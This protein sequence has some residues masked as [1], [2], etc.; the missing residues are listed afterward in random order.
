M[1]FRKSLVALLVVALVLGSAVSASAGTAFPDVANTKYSDASAR[2]AGLGVLKGYQDGTFKPD[3]KITRA[4]F[5]AVAVR[6]LGLEA[7]AKL[8]TGATQFPDVPASHWSSGYVNVAVNQGL[9]KGYPDGTFK[10]DANVTNAEALAILVRVIGRDTFVKGVWP[11]N[12]I[13]EA[14]RLGIDAGASLNANDSATR[15]DV[16]LFSSEALTTNVYEQQTTDTGA[17]V[18]RDTGKT[19][20]EKFLGVVSGTR[21]VSDTPMLFSSALK[22]NEVTLY[23]STNISQPWK[24]YTVA[25]GTDVRRM[26]GEIVT[27]YTK[28]DKLIYVEPKYVSKVERVAASEDLNKVNSGKIPLLDGTDLTFTGSSVTYFNNVPYDLSNRD[29][30]GTHLSWNTAR[31]QDVN[32]GHFVRYTL[33]TDG[34]VRSAQFFK[35]A[36]INTTTSGVYVVKEAT[37][38]S[39]KFVAYE[40]KVGATL[41]DPANTTFDLSAARYTVWKG[42]FKNPTAGSLSDVKADTIVHWIKG[43]DSTGKKVYELFVTDGTVTGNVT[44]VSTSGGVFYFNVGDTQLRISGGYKDG[45][46]KAAT[47]DGSNYANLL[48]KNVKVLKDFLGRARS[49]AFTDTSVA[50]KLYGLVTKMPWAVA[51][52]VGTTGYI[53]VVKPDGSS[54]TFE[55]T[56]DTKISNYTTGFATA[57]AV[58]DL[59]VFLNGDGTNDADIIEGDVIRYT[60]TSDGKLEAIAGAVKR[61]DGVRLAAAGAAKAAYTTTANIGTTNT[62]EKTTVVNANATV[63]NDLSGAS[64]SNE[65]LLYGSDTVIFNTKAA[66]EYGSV[67]VASF[68]NGTVLMGAAV[69]TTNSSFVRAEVIVISNYTTLGSSV[70]YGFVKGLARAAGAT[71]YSLTVITNSGEA[72][73]EWS[74]TTPTDFVRSLQTV[75]DGTYTDLSYWA[76]STLLDDLTNGDAVSFKVTADGKV[77][78]LRELLPAEASA[79]LG[80]GSNNW[81]Y[82]T[83]ISAVS[84][85]GNTLTIKGDKPNAPAT[86][87]TTSTDTTVGI[88]SDTVVIDA[89][90][91][92]PAKVTLSD[93]QNGYT[94]RVY[95]GWATTN[96]LDTERSLIAKVIV[97]T[98]K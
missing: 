56:K 3:G 71:T 41:T 81:D 97:I 65:T 14:A 43:A 27:A 5:A 87:G 25:E 72:A 15:G 85:S 94:V 79:T 84:V 46:G 90:G 83:K 10:P 80:L 61:A 30:A 93:L 73:R 58:S 44:Q 67:T 68:E 32:G 17:I 40:P 12:Y 20:Q 86:S 33:Y 4:E 62:T 82:T 6:L 36:D 57:T 2:L 8:T 19:L 22:D 18:Y 74:A 88:N 52:S 28:D 45:A 34:S 29:G 77:T 89:S 54:A 37:P 95:K 39:K 64:A 49:V 76:T 70:Q 7:A 66:A 48:G 78:D 38:D 96:E 24:T 91:S 42:D 13:A 50:T 21:T 69:A 92:T 47:L 11:A 59:D 53:K 31:L 16:A 51:T 55:L 23:D 26:F 35:Y 63:K 1:Q 75:T 98:A 60:L 9:L